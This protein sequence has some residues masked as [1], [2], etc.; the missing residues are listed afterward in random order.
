MKLIDFF[1]C[2]NVIKLYDSRGKKFATLR[3][4]NEEFEIISM[5]A[6]TGGQTVEEFIIE[7]IAS[8]ADDQ[9]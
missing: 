5:A 4:D 2:R 8:L 7:L 6:E 1:T 3:L 9:K